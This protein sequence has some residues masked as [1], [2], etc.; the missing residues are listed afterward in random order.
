M[1]Y[2]RRYGKRKRRPTRRRRK[3]KKTSVYKIAVKAARN[4]LTCQ[5]DPM[6]SRTELGGYD[7]SDGQ[8]GPIIN[9][10]PGPNNGV[11][12]N[13]IPDVHQVALAGDIG[14]PG[15]RKDDM[16]LIKGIKVSFR[17]FL[18]PG[19]RSLKWV[20]YLAMDLKNL[21]LTK[22]FNT[23]DQWTMLREEAQVVEDLS[24]I[25]ILK[26]KYNTF[27]TLD[28]D[29]KTAFKDVN[30]YWR[31]KKPFKLKYSASG[32]TDYLNRKFVVCIKA[33]YDHQNDQNPIYLQYAGVITTYYRDL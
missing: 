6:Y 19:C 1:P 16:I 3:N 31:P 13:N 20:T 12:I 26:T 11:L 17:F 7:E 14:N 21:A 22:L 25:R 24:S 29:S 10:P 5:A 30:M 28:D 27:N 32:N 9:V 2:K 8:Y 15:T 23:P 33:S 18:P 4:V